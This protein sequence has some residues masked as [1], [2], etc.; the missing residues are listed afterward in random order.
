MFQQIPKER[1]TRS[2][3][4]VRILCLEEGVGT[5]KDLRKILVP[6]VQVQTQKKKKKKNNAMIWLH[7]MLL[8]SILSDALPQSLWSYQTR[9][10]AD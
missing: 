3:C 1:E 2:Y 7:Y 8:A 4:D 9:L 5:A 10:P 6:H